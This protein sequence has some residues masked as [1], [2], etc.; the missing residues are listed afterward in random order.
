MGEG[1]FE[2]NLFR[3]A[4][5]ERGGENPGS[6][7]VLSGREERGGVGC[8]MAFRVYAMRNKRPLGYD[9]VGTR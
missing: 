8:S 7:I 2:G 6:G 4:T 5:T 9:A 3:R 1:A